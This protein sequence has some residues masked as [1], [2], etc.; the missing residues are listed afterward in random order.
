MTR[1]AILRETTI[2]RFTLRREEAAA[3]LS[4]SP[5]HFDTWVKDGKMPKG[6]KIGAIVLWD[7]NEISEAWARLRD[8]D[9]DDGSNAFD[10]FVA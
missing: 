3:A 5:S 2:P 1:A 4:I 10:G 6:H 9:N 7:T 8:A